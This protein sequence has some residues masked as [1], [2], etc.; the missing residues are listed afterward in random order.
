[1]SVSLLTYGLNESENIESFLLW[2]SK[3]LKKISKNYEI[4]YIDD[5]STDDSV[6]RVK[7]IKKKL[8]L[9]IKVYKNQSNKG[10]AYSLKKGIRLCKKDFLIIQ[11]V[12]RCYNLN[13]FLKYKKKVLSGE[14]D[15]LHGN[16]PKS[17][18]TRS[19]NYY[20]GVISF[21]NWLLIS[22]LFGFKINDYQNTYFIKSKIIKKIKIY[23]N[24]SFS[25]AELILKLY[26]SKI[27]ILETEVT[28]RKRILG[29][30]KGTG[31]G[32]IAHSICEI[33]FY[34]I[35]KKKYGL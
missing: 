18:Y 4:V 28:F 5:G 17:I 16:R 14:V 23:S 19:D 35:F 15:C 7:I 32:K 24:S 2:A 34:F 20:K 6:Q 8:N 25:N 13:N 29:I 31:F 27:K 30:S 22:L 9:K 33:F 11:M 1:M 26:K 10:S 21:I 12:D 3:F